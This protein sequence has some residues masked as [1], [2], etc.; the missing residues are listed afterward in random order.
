[1]ESYEPRKVVLWH[2]RNLTG[3]RMDST[4]NTK[5]SPPPNLWEAV[6]EQFVCLKLLRFS[7]QESCLLRQIQ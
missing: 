2:Y 5:H 4:R 1:M 7:A 6:R 3:I